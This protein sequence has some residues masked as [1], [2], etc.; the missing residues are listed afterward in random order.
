MALVSPGISITVSDQSQYVNSNVGSVPLVLL[1]TAENK[2]YNGATATGTTAANAGQLLSFSSQR[3]LI[4]QMGTPTFQ[5]SAAGT[6]VNGS[7][8]NEYGLMAAYSALGLSNQLYAIRADVDLNQLTGTSVRP[9]GAPANNTY[10]LDLVNTTWGIQQLN[11]ATNAFTNQTPL[12]ITSESQ[13]SGTPAVPLASIGQIGQYA[14]VFVNSSGTGTAGVADPIRLFYKVGAT[15]TSGSGYTS[16]NN[17]WVQVGSANWQASLPVATGN[18]TPTFTVSTTYT[19]SINNTTVTYTPSGSPG[20]V[21]GLAA[22]INSAAIAGIYAN[23][24]SAGYLQLF[25]TS[26]ATGYSGSGVGTAVVVD[27]TN[28]PLN[29]CGIT[30]QT[31]NCPIL[32]Y[33]NYAV[34]PT[35]GWF[36]TVPSGGTF[37]G[38]PSG[39]IWWQTGAI[40]GGMNLVLKQYSSATSTFVPLTV[41]AYGPLSGSTGGLMSA[42]YG[43]DPLGGG[44]NIAVGQVYADY[45]LY[46]SS[47]S[48]S[49][50]FFVNTASGVTSATGAT[51]ATSIS[52]SFTIQATQ[53]GTTTLT[54]I[55]TVTAS[56]STATQVVQ[57]IQALNIP[58]VTAS[59]TSSG[60]VNLTHTAG[61]VIILTNTSSTPLGSNSGSPGLGFYSGGGSNYYVAGT[62]VVYITDFSD[63][64]SSIDDS[65]TQPYT[66]PTSGTYWY[67]SNPADIDIMINDGGHWRGYRSTSLALDA[68]GYNLQATDPNGV[69]ITPTTAPTTKSTGSA[70]TAGDLWLDSGD[71]ENFPSLY[72][73]N[74]TTWVAIN[75][76]D[77]TSLNGII[78]ADAR[79]DT[80]GTTD[81][82]TGSLPSIP[83]LLLSDWVDQDVPDPRLY[84][85]GTL[86]FNTRRSGYNVKK[87]VA[88]YFNSTSFPNPGSVPGTSGSLNTA[89][90]GAAWVSAAGLD[91]NGV[92]YAGSKAQRAII[93]GAMQSAIDS[94]LDVLSPIYNFNLICAP[95]YP[96]LIP[97]MLTLNDNR[98]DTAFVIGD[99]PMDLA[100]NTVDITNWV[101]NE[102]GSGLPSDAAS[103]P[104]LALYYPAG[105]TNDLSGNQ[106]VVPAS[107][108][109]L[110]TYLY[111]DQVAYPWFAPAG[112][113]R[114]LV[115]NLNNIG[116]IDSATGL[117]VQNSVSQG[118]R[119]SL[120]TLQINPITQLPNSGLVIFG[121]LTRAASSSA[122]NRVNVV[123]LENYLRRTFTT[124]SNG[125]LFEP[126]DATTR[127]SI[128]HQIESALGN[129]LALRGLYDFLVICDT[130]NNTSATIANNQ[131]YV[132]V[133]IEPI[134]D[135]EFIYIPIAIYNPGEIAALNVQSS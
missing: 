95:N 6:P 73:Y 62:G 34:S 32:L 51:P 5:L 29:K 119:D 109:V 23:A 7:E 128:A 55:Q 132:D 53:P 26:A 47:S 25:V 45:S 72:R 97:N 100:P 102:T 56:T 13:V 16:Y 110:R 84:A 120:F 104:Y 127:K 65:L 78:F 106:I 96:E 31:Y 130:S 28:T 86:L 129:V 2:T 17:T 57:A 49:L 91:S 122:Q 1:A 37:T 124:I 66:A 116:Y 94:N 87:Y 27:G 93:V 20:T 131:L 42:T 64:T 117:F 71:L 112:V 83:A 108:A 82:I 135:V 60:T 52:G 9:F 44:T 8:I 68:R 63:I 14:L 118:L 74:G 107:H 98:G 21:A 134:K 111:N 80:S 69:I 36:S 10:W 3:D 70:L 39:S 35:N 125:Y 54:T 90:G 40:G 79:W 114:G 67:Y 15:T 123:R 50:K 75:N 46:D 38:Y 59:I 76:Q 22:A 61:G 113:N 77:H 133:A 103:S 58:Y 115:S 126:N 101:N 12:L 19:L 24:T 33:G 43:L 89:D 4:T 30:A 11:S 88:D 18:A 85:R 92:M 121:Q 81:L 105:Q 41:P 48:N 99:T